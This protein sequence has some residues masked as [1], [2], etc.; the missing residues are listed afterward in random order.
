MLTLNVEA[1]NHF[2]EN[3]WLLILIVIVETLNYFV[4]DSVGFGTEADW[5]Y[6]VLKFPI[7]VYVFP[8]VLFKNKSEGKIKI[9]SN[10]A[11]FYGLMLY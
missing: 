3:L 4:R 10:V 5:F 2:E 11:G 7:Y 6:Q 9:L 1:Y 8:K